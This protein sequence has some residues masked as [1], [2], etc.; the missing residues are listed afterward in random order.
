MPLE[1][2]SLSCGRTHLSTILTYGAL[3]QQL[4]LL[5]AKVNEV[6]QIIPANPTFCRFE[7]DHPTLIVESRLKGCTSR[8]EDVDQTK[9]LCTLFWI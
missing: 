3:I 6:R 4:P 8:R 2:R 1:D 5:F 7:P 9:R